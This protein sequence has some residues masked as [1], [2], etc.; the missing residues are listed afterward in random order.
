MVSPQ[1]KNVVSLDGRIWGLEFEEQRVQVRNVV[2]R[3]IKRIRYVQLR[4][5]V[6]APNDT[7]EIHFVKRAKKQVVFVTPHSGPAGGKHGCK[8]KGTEAETDE[9][10]SG[11][12]REVPRG[13]SP[14]TPPPP[15]SFPEAA[16]ETTF[17]LRFSEQSS[18]AL[19]I[20][21]L[22]EGHLAC[23]NRKLEHTVNR[24]YSHIGKGPPTPKKTPYQLA[25]ELS[26]TS[27]ASLLSSLVFLKPDAVESQVDLTGALACRSPNTPRGR[28]P[29]DP[30]PML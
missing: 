5:L 21:Q 17:S 9:N 14:P 12:A 7:L 11:N 13:F 10:V 15:I 30:D 8:V 22:Q 16:K 27:R 28:A 24:G 18:R 6:S 19:A 20:T 23:T 26:P 1:I 4:R 2:T 29:V 3:Q 25:S